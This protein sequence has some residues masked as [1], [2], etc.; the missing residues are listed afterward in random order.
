MADMYLFI[1]LVSKVQE[2]E[3]CF[4]FDAFVAFVDYTFSRPLSDFLWI[5]C[6]LG[7]IFPM[8]QLNNYMTLCPSYFF[9]VS[10]H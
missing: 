4:N 8:V 3:L 7:F 6:E 9:Q 5:F 10:F 1:H 2:H